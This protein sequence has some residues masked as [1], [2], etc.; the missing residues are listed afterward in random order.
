MTGLI[1]VR[2]AL[3]LSQSTPQLFALTNFKCQLFT[4]ILNQQTNQTMSTQ[5]KS[6]PGI[7]MSGLVILFMLFDSIMKFIQ[8]DEVIEGTVKLGFQEHHIL[9]IGVIGF[10]ATL[11]YI[12][13]RTSVIGAIL[14]TGYFGGAIVTNFRLDQPLFS[15]ILFPIYIS[16]L[17]WGGLIL[18]NPS[19][20]KFLLNHQTLN[21]E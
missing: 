11:F 17:M 9:P 3:A 1:D 5:R 14:L 4:R 7:I 18:R 10:L 13:P 16:I 12:I 2:Y 21:N 15:H 20:K 19:L 6:I 8:P